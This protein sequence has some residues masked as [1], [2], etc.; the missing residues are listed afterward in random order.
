M[1]PLGFPSAGG[2]LVLDA[3]PRAHN[4]S[5]RGL[6]AISETILERP[7]DFYLHTKV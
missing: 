6:G 7:F 5:R 3:V 2:I 4:C 1:K